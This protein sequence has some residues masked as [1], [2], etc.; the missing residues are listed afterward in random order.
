MFIHH[1]KLSC[2]Q[3]GLHSFKLN[4]GKRER[5]GLNKKSR[6]ISQTWSTIAIK[7]QEERIFFTKILNFSKRFLIA[8]FSSFTYV[9][10]SFQTVYKL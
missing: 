1:P 5:E 10:S 4:Q 3:T 8:T 2:I 9:Y 7:I 6:Q